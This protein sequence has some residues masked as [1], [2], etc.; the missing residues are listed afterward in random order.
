MVLAILVVGMIA[1]HPASP[2]A[3]DPAAGEKAVSTFERYLSEFGAKAPYR[4][5]AL[6]E[7][8]SNNAGT[9]SWQVRMGTADHQSYA[10]Y[11]NPDGKPASIFRGYEAYE[12]TDLPK[13]PRV[14]PHSTLITRQ[15]D[16]LLRF[17]KSHDELGA[18]SLVV[19]PG[20]QVTLYA[21]FL[22]NGYPFAGIGSGVAVSFRPDLH[23]V[24]SMR[25]NVGSTEVKGTRPVLSQTQANTAAQ[26]ALAK[27]NFKNP[28]YDLDKVVLTG[29]SHLAYYQEYG[30]GKANLA[31]MVEYKVTYKD[32]PRS[33]MRISSWPINLPTIAEIAID[34]QNSQNLGTNVLLSSSRFTTSTKQEKVGKYLLSDNSLQPGATMQMSGGSS[35]EKE[36]VGELTRGTSPD[37]VSLAHEFLKKSH[38]IGRYY[39]SGL[40]RTDGYIPGKKDMI[41]GLAKDEKHF[42]DVLMDPATGKVDFMT[43]PISTARV[44]SFV[45]TADDL[46][47]GRM[48]VSRMAPGMA[49]APVESLGVS[50]EGSFAAGAG[51]LS[52]GLPFFNLNPTYGASVSFEIGERRML[53]FNRTDPPK[54]E[55]PEPKIT[56]EQAKALLIKFAPGASDRDTASKTLL[57][58]QY[59]SRVRPVL[60][61]YKL[62]SES[63]VRLVWEGAVDWKPAATGPYGEVGTMEFFIDA[64]TGEVIQ[65]DDRF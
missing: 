36:Y 5:Q 22:K 34:A 21:P 23:L 26:N 33:G 44:S 14:K 11:F 38:I 2:K 7:I 29:K 63:S 53:T 46:K 31:Y 40:S 13:A 62:K 41:V 28:W 64:H 47:F 65:P 37:Y 15:A 48:L 61:F 24:T 16:R 27:M 56:S 20:N 51:A 1:Q 49:L 35:A 55:I 43:S 8:R 9:G 57:S 54:T 19:N 32:K 59:P 10:A 45:P 30:Q 52:H 42:Y 58:K 39:L 60:G 18:P 4:V 25:R 6:G 3:F 12:Q 50:P 17:L